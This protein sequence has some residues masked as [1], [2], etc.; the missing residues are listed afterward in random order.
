[1]LFS[2]VLYRVNHNEITDEGIKLLAPAI[3]ELKTLEMLQYVNHTQP[4]TSC[5]VP[6]LCN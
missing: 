5:T 1:M 2:F 4:F 6:R 3:K